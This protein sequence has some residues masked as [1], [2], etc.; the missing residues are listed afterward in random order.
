MSASSMPTDAP[1]A[2]RASAMLTAVVDLPTPP[3]PEATAMMFFTPGTSFTPRC[4]TCGATLAATL[5]VTPPTPGSARSRAA[6]CLRIGS[7]CVFAG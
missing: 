5:T 3:F 6:T 7:I 1:S 2:A 4:A